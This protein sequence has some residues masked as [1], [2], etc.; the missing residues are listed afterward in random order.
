MSRKIPEEKERASSR[1]KTHAKKERIGIASKFVKLQ[2]L[3]FKMA[4]QTTGSRQN[5]REYQFSFRT[6]SA[7]WTLGESSGWRQQFESNS[8]DYCMSETTVE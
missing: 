8:Y 1:E 7:S 2:I 3:M 6:E 4:K 5:D